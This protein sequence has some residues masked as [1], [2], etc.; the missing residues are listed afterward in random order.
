[1]VDDD[2]D[3]EDDEPM[4]EFFSGEEESD[5]EKIV[6]SKGRLRRARDSDYPEEELACEDESQ[7]DDPHEEVK[8][9][10]NSQHEVKKRSTKAKDKK[11]AKKRK[12]KSSD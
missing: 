2:A 6:Q 10:S 3:L 12:S 1:M 8:S 7:S 5:D 9:D 11:K 4:V